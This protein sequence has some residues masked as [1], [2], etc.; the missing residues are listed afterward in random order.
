MH[1][2]EPLAQDK[3]VSIRM[4]EELHDRLEALVPRMKSD[5]R[6]RSFPGIG[7]ATVI[8]LALERGAT[9]LETDLAEL[10]SDSKGSKS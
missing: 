6:Y 7:R 10:P 4:T 2:G 3:T 5:P 8:R 1:I 9:I